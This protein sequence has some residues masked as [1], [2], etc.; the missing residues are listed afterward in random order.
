MQRLPLRRRGVLLAGAA[1]T[2]PALGAAAAPRFDCRSAFLLN[3]HHFAL[4]AAR[5]DP[6]LAKLAWTA[7][8]TA[9][10]RRA[11]EAAV[12]HH[13]RAYG[14]RHPLFDEDMS[15]QRQALARANAA[16]RDAHGLGLPQA[17]EA[18]LND[19][20]PAYARC[21]WPAH[22]AGNRRWSAIAS[23]LD[24][25]HGAAIVERLQQRLGPAASRAPL[26]VDVVWQTGTFEG[27]FTSDTPPHVVMP[28]A[29]TD[30]QGLASLE[31]LHHEAGHTGMLDPVMAL[32]EAELARRPRRGADMLWHAIQFHTVGET[33]REVLAAAGIGYRPY[34]EQR[35][36][37]ERAPGWNLYLPLLR[38][39]WQAWV[40]GRIA[41]AEAIARMVAALPAA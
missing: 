39:H 38:T 31:M 13:G 24:A 6:A 33:T 3:L 2:L 18:A 40:D 21:L 25:V 9:G 7:E 23:A 1:L 14:D 36:L 8:P 15:A 4:H 28:S 20:A 37:F 35:G 17:L 5:H 12:A 27:A 30:Y 26:R 16:R 19:A 41:Q 29:R 22:D 10:E 32:I 34:A 11:L